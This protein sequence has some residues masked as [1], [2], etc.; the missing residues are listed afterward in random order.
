MVKIKKPAKIIAI[1]I[2]HIALFMIFLREKDRS[3][4]QNEII[5]LGHLNKDSNHV[6]FIPSKNL[7]C[8]FVLEIPKTYNLA[9]LPVSGECKVTVAESTTNF[10]FFVEHSCDTYNKE[11]NK[12]MLFPLTNGPAVKGLLRLGVKCKLTLTFN[13]S[14]LKHENIYLWF[15]YLYT[16]NMIY[17]FWGHRR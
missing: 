2:V 4:P 1:T 12:Y 14:S 6:S 5:K 8:Y 11:S 10:L 17:D 16:D 9:S 13:E 15:Q 3:T 7:S